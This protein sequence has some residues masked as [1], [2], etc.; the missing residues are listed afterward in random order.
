M[1]STKLTEESY[2]CDS[3]Y[4]YNKLTNRISSSEQHLLYESDLNNINKEYDGVNSSIR[5]ILELDG[6]DTTVLMLA[7][8]TL[9]IWGWQLR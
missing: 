4:T 2:T 5:K 6:L 7:H 9:N 1:A 8:W 3:S